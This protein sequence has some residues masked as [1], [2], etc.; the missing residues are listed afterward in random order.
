MTDWLITLYNPSGAAAKD[1]S[2]IKSLTQL[3]PLLAIESKNSSYYGLYVKFEN[4]V[5]KEALENLLSDK[6]KVMLCDS[7][8]DAVYWRWRFGV[9][10][11]GPVNEYTKFDNM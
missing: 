1:I 5:S 2:C 6:H 10:T 8:R 3:N 11:I 4:S 7:E 9:D